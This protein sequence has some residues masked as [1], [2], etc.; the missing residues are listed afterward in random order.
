[1]VSSLDEAIQ[2]EFDIYCYETR[3][4]FDNIEA[5]L[6]YFESNTCLFDINNYINDIEKL[7]RE[8]RLY[9][10]WSQV[11]ESKRRNFSVPNPVFDEFLKLYVNPI[12]QDMKIH[13]KAHGGENGWSTKRSLETHL[14]VETAFS[15]DMEDAFSNVNIRHVFQFF[16]KSF[17][18]RKFSGFLSFLL[19]NLDGDRRI[20]PQ[21]ATHSMAM[22]NRIL[23]EFDAE[24]EAKC[25]E[26]DF[27]Y[28]RW[29]DDMTIS[30]SSSLEMNE[31]CGAIKLAEKYFPVAKCKIF[32]QKMPDNIY[33][34]G[35]MIQQNKVSKNSKEERERNK[36]L[37]IDYSYHFNSESKYRKW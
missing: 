16:Y 34:L 29:V 21:G 15:F 1:M 7:Y 27:I 19:T 22:F 11:I 30:S 18:D 13:P 25:N 8:G 2:K 12:I 23:Y 6:D 24:I 28:T 14:P 35:H 3:N 9:R 33:L 36:A 10:K 31:F 5:C 17:N 37:P 20:L 26:R 32:F 4:H